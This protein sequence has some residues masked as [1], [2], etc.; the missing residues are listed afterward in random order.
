MISP[1]VSTAVTD[2]TIAMVGE[3]TLSR[4]SGKASMATALQSSKVTNIQ[5]YLSITL[6][7]LDALFLAYSSPLASISNAKRSIEARPTV[8]PDIRP[9]K[10]VRRIEMHHEIILSFLVIDG[11]KVSLFDGILQ[12]NFRLSC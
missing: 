3:T 6:K 11:S 4:K 8:S 12:T 5:W 9:P 7:I 2:I 10:R 1:N